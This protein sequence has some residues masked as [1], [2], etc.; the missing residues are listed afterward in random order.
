MHWWQS[1]FDEDYVDA[2]TAA[3]AFDHTAEQARAIGALIADGP[4][5]EILDVGCGFGRIAGPLHQQGY[6]VTGIDASPAQLRLAQQ[7]NPGP[8]YLEADM[9]HPPPGPYDAVLNVFSSFGYFERRDD[10]VAALRAWS[11]VLRT[12]GVLLMELLHRD[13]LAYGYGREDGPLN[14]GPVHET[15]VTDWV[16]GTR[17]ATLTFGD[18]TKTFR[19]RLYTA[20]ELVRELRAVGFG[21]VEVWG[22]LDGATPLSPQTRL[23]LR[24]VA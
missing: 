12:G 15:G 18:V 11:S 5:S 21:H 8:A 14:Q 4:G 20:T 1:M 17:T 6:D 7:R 16:E 3:G 19:V 24:A 23:V 22:D 13:R 9:R 2:L 10:D